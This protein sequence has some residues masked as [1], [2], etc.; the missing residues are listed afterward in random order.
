SR[1]GA[2]ALMGDKRLK[3]I[4]VRGT[5]DINVAD[6]IRFMEL[7]DGIIARSEWVRDGVF[8][9]RV[10]IAGYARN[11]DYYNRSGLT[12]PE[13]ERKI[14]GIRTVAKKF[15]L[16]NRDRETGCYNCAQRCHHTYLRPNDGGYMYIKCTSWGAAT[17]ATGLFDMDFTL[18]FYDL[19]EKYGLDSL[20]VANEVAFAIDLY[21]RG[22]LTAEDTGGMHLEWENADVALWL[23]EK[24]T[25]REGIGDVLADGVYWAAKRIGRGA[26]EYAYFVKKYDPHPF[27]REDNAALC[28]AINDKGDSTKALGSTPD[29]IWARPDREA[30]MNSEFFPYP[31]EFKKF[32][33][34]EPDPMAEDSAGAVEFMTYNEETYALADAMGE[35]Y[36]YAGRYAWP[37]ISPRSL[38]AELISAATG[39]DIDEAR[40]TGIARRTINLVRAY[41]VRAGMTRQEDI[42][43]DRYFKIPR[44]AGSN[45]VSRDL[46]N[47]WVDRWYERRGWDKEGIP[48]KS[49]L[50][51]LG[52]DYVIE[53]LEQR[54]ILVTPPPVLVT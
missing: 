1:G 8:E 2:G 19:I 6:P 23:V 13:L 22:I 49:T 4:A 32:L 16:E 17:I 28:E 15:I 38:I 11:G 34:T 24:I 39:M 31:E 53:D 45:F 52:L 25:R 30:Y 20:A 27:K 29:A 42:L 10:A 47:K 51:E 5:K 43:P 54:G 41:N 48:A 14:D 3:A 18:D 36:F 40:A 46:L 37:S 33:R 50:A 35:C 21:Q 9:G 26:E 12:T 7:C 44:P